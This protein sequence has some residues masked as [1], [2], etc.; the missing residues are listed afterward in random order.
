MSREFA[1]R[2]TVRF[3]DVDVLGHVNNAV[4][5]T[6]METARTEFWLQL[7][8]SQNLM[9]LSFVVVHAECDFKSP[10]HFGDEIEVGIR[11][12]SIGN[13][14]FVWDYEIRNLKTGG[15]FAEGKTIQV[16][17]NHVTKQSSRVPDAVRQ[18]L[19]SKAE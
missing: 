18:K 7:F 10:A 12:T 6:Y 16:F 11:T 3:R 19:T 15:L 9:D 14:S 17:Y 2:F 1:V 5:F 8:G 4:Y 13:S